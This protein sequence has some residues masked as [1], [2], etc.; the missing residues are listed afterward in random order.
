[1]ATNP[2]AVSP[3]LVLQAATAV[4]GFALQNATPT[5]ISWTAPNDGRQH[6]VTVI[7]TLHVTVA[8]TGGAVVTNFT[9]PDAGVGQSTA[10]AG[11]AGTGVFI[12][13]GPQMAV[14][15]AGTTVSVAQSSALTVGAALLWAEIWA[16]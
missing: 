8:E 10:F 9:A 2:S 11:G 15:G 4:A 6:R 5:V 3:G 16:T 12:P 14:V 1:M 13:N 7:Y